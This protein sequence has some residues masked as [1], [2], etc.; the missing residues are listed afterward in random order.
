MTQT[1]KSDPKQVWETL[2]NFGYPE[3]LM[4]FYCPLDGEH[5]RQAQS[6]IMAFPEWKGGFARAGLP[7][8]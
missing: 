6:F 2:K 8:Q 4:I 5:T 7:D 3:N 1:L